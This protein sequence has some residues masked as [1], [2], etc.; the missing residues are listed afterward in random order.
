MSFITLSANILTVL[1]FIYT[2]ESTRETSGRSLTL[3]THNEFA[4]V[5]SRTLLK[6]VDKKW[7][8]L[9][10]SKTTKLP[11]ILNESWSASLS[12]HTPKYCKYWEQP[13][14]DL[15]TIKSLT[16][17]QLHKPNSSSAAQEASSDL[18]LHC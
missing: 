4:V 10:K 7:Q 3:F 15:F 18:S 11:G 17:C 13:H 9:L 5:K 1:L 12:C 14:V 2:N 6:G 16:W 8:K